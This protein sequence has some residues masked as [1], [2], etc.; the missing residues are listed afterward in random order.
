MGSGFKT[1]VG[2]LR[3]QAEHWEDWAGNAQKAL[4]KMSSGV[5]QGHKLGWKAEEEGASDAYDE[6]SEAMEQALKDAKWSF[7]YLAS[8]LRSTADEYDASDATSAEDSRRL[9]KLI[10]EGHAPEPKPKP[11]D[12]PPHITPTRPI[13]PG[14]I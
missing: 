6:W 5:G 7:T 4:D 9:D 10:N 1:E 2:L 8:A 13:K 11:V 3:K 12:P 14:E